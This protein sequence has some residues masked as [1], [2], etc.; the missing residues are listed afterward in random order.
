MPRYGVRSLAIELDRTHSAHKARG[1]ARQ[2]PVDWV[3]SPRTAC[4]GGSPRALGQG[5]SPT[6][7][8]PEAKAWQ[9]GHRT[10]ALEKIRRPGEGEWGS[11]YLTAIPWSSDHPLDMGRDLGSEGGQGTPLCLVLTLSGGAVGNKGAG[12]LATRWN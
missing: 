7:E 3:F 10:W 11:E 8:P 4:E 1:K 12:L 5:A 9:W 2:N 6:G